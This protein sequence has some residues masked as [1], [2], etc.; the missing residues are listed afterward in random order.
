[1]DSR[2]LHQVIKV[3]AYLTTNHFHCVCAY[4]YMYVDGDLGR[5]PQAAVFVDTPQN[6]G[7]HIILPCT[8][9]FQYV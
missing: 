1:M 3:C 6:V 7:V 5:H 9:I 8:C 2:K 4:M